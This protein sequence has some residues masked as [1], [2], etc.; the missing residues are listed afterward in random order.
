M[1]LKSLLSKIQDPDRT[2]G[3][4]LQIL[5]RLIQQKN[6]RILKR[7]RIIIEPKTKTPRFVGWGMTSTHAL[8]W[9]LKSST[10][11]IGLKFLEAENNLLKRLSNGEF[12]T[13]SENVLRDM[14]GYRWRHY[15]LYWSATLA[16][17]FTKSSSCNFV[18]AGVWEG[19]TVYFAASALKEETGL[20]R[21]PT[22]SI[23]CLGLDEIRVLNH[24]RV[25]SNRKLFIS[26][27]RP[28]QSQLEGI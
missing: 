5:V 9:D 4:K 13:P 1:N 26:L 20:Q 11:I 28:D 6:F 10:D 15:F 19:M 23:R 21:L 2:W 24:K 7:L 16:T 22:L 14:S 18:E 3:E 27:F 8:P 17:R 25:R 12:V